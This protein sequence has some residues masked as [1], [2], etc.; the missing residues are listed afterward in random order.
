MRGAFNYARSLISFHLRSSKRAT[1][2]SRSNNCT[3]RMKE[4]CHCGAPT[5]KKGNEFRLH[6]PSSSFSFPSLSLDLKLLFLLL[7]F[8]LLFHPSP[9]CF[10]SLL[11]CSSSPRPEW[12][13]LAGVPLPSSP[14]Y[15]LFPPISSRAPQ[16]PKTPPEKTPSCVCIHGG[17][18][19]GQG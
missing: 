5:K 19:K 17:P 3:A 2:M 11:G 16:P 18:A 13:S 15:F 8:L 7:L 4:E 12:D 10:S 14:S 1:H 6:P 9:L